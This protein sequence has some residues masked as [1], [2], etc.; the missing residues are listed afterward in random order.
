MKRI[1]IIFLVLS[2]TITGC[3]SSG[4]NQS[5]EKLV[6]NDKEHEE[7][8]LE[9][10]VVK[11]LELELESIDWDKAIDETKEELLDPEWFS[12]V[13]DIHIGVDN[14]KNNITL[15]AVISDATNEDTAVDFADTIIRRFSSNVAMQSSNIKAP[16]HE[17]LGTIFDYYDIAVGVAP[18]SKTDNQKEWYVSDY[19]GKKTHRNP[20]ANK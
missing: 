9:E 17:Y 19:I 8:S 5:E 7:S 6:T 3:G 14:E 11:N 20:K 13:K 12:Y 10:E 1:L 16:G 2:I 18:S 4:N 15:T